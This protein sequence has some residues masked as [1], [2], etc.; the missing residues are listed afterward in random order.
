MF[1]RK[2]CDRFNGWRKMGTDTFYELMC[3]MLQTSLTQLI[4]E[5]M[6]VY[7]RFQRTTFFLFFFFFLLWMR[8][9]AFFRIVYFII[10]QS[11][12]SKANISYVT[13][14]HGIK[15]DWQ[16]KQNKIVF[17]VEILMSK[18]WTRIHSHFHL[19][20]HTANDSGTPRK[21]VYASEVQWT[22]YAK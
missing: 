16:L 19:D 5:I 9:S 15:T 12:I 14:F 17:D 22:K 6:I 8:N 7:F 2:N 20:T 3:G 4:A 21:I 18:S 1:V 10:F 13:Y 11:R